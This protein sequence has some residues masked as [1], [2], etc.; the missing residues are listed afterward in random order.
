[1]TL[2]ETKF[3]LL[4]IEALYPNCNF[5]DPVVTSKIWNSVLYD[6]EAANIMQALKIYA[7]TD[8]SGFAPSPGKLIEIVDNTINPTIPIE[9]AADMVRRAVSNS[10]YNSIEEFQK[11]P[12]AI[13]KA[14]VSPSRLASW[15][16]TDIDEFETVCMSHF[17]KSYKICL[18]REQLLL[19]GKDSKMP[20]ETSIQQLLQLKE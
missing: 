12:P 15:A 11:L 19:A 10:L 8:G 3:L 16:R 5:K 14:V 6:Q 7:R 4:S 13:Q 2:D 17:R 9:N 18:K 20:I 1:M